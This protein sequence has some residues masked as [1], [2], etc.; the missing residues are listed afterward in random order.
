MHKWPFFS[1]N[2]AGGLGNI[3]NENSATDSRNLKV[4]VCYM[5]SSLDYFVVS[6]K[7]MS[8]QY[9]ASP[10]L[11]SSWIKIRNYA[12]WFHFSLL[13]S[14]FYWEILVL[15]KAALFFALSVVS[16]T[17][18]QRWNNYSILSNFLNTRDDFPFP[19]L[20]AVFPSSYLTTMDLGNCWCIISVTNIGIGG[21]HNSEVWNMGHCWPGEVQILWLN[22]TSSTSLHWF[23]V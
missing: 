18:H 13:C 10:L 8:L 16:L 6:S 1:A 20:H 5:L 4:K 12:C 14:W 9:L 7:F 19:F 11:T 15:G 23:L 2:S 22:R 3:N 17:P 21:F